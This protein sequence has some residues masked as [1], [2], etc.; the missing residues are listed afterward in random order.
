MNNNAWVQTRT[1]MFEIE[2]FNHWA[3]EAVMLHWC[4]VYGDLVVKFILM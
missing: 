2:A 1:F 3:T 4:C